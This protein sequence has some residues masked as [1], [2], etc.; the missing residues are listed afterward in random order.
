MSKL[1]DKVL[2]TIKEPKDYMI[3]QNYEDNRSNK[4]LI[5][6]LII[7][8]IVVGIVVSAKMAGVKPNTEQAQQ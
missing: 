6:M 4:V 5:I 1:N 2:D 7:I 8:I 3:L